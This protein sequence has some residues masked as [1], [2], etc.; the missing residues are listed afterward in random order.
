MQTA[1]MLLQTIYVITTWLCRFAK[2]WAVAKCN[3]CCFEIILFVLI[4]NELHGIFSGIAGF[5]DVRDE[6]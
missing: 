2:V 5:I 4:L 1:L 6:Q 3:F